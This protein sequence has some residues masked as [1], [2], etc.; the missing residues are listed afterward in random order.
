MT[1]RALPAAWEHVVDGGG[2]R[3]S[4]PPATAEPGA[5]LRAL[6]ERAAGADP[7]GLRLRAEW[8]DARADDLE[9]VVH[10]G[11]LLPAGVLRALGSAADSPAH[12]L[13]G[14]LRSLGHHADVL[15]Y[16][17]EVLRAGAGAVE[18]VRA[19]H[20]H[21]LAAVEDGAPGAA[22]DASTAGPGELRAV[23]ARSCM[24]TAASM[25]RIG[26]VLTEELGA[27]PVDGRN[28]GDSRV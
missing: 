2:V 21:A 23:F 15:R 25:H 3:G 22:R 28:V 5:D 1:P 4:D 7:M 16:V 27:T 26:E 8:C 18:T 20:A 17:A 11:R 6:W 19:R 13:E 14:G 10:E 12:D 9:G 24:Q